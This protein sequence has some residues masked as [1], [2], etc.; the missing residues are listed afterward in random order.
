MAPTPCYFGLPKDAKAAYEFLNRYSNGE[1]IETNPRSFF[2]FK[3]E[4]KD[5][6]ISVFWGTKDPGRKDSNITYSPKFRI[7]ADSPES[8]TAEYMQSIN[9]KSDWKPFPFSEYGNGLHKGACSCISAPYDIQN[10]MFVM[11]E[12]FFTVKNEKAWPYCQERGHE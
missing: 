12:V 5:N 9:G 3:I 11:A 2:S 7:R 1:T 4:K 8:Y 6:T 10:T